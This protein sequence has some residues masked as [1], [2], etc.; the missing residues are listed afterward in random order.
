[1]PAKPSA[2]PEAAQVRVWKAELKDLAKQRRKVIRDFTTAWSQLNKAAKAANRA[3]A[4]FEAR[5]KKTKPRALASID[6]RVGIL[7]GRI[8]I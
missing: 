4:V 7:H 1:M 6:R 2:S 5:E 8:G 3:L